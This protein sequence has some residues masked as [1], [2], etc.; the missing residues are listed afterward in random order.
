M[1]TLKNIVLVVM[2]IFYVNVGI[3]HFLEPE[4]FLYIIPPYLNS[5]GL[6]LVYLSG[7][8]EIFLGLLLLFKKY[9]KYACYALI[10]LLIA[11][12]P[13][14][15]YLAFNEAPQKLINIT[16]FM[17]SWVR[18]PLQFVLIGLAYYFSKD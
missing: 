9:R 2:S 14:N 3:K 16:P 12:Y 17:A 1:K 5:I 18:L 7:F 15:I 13:A 4:W 6:E 10:I 11:V 8:F